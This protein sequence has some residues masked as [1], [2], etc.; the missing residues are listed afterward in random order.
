MISSPGNVIIV[1][2]TFPWSRMFRIVVY[3]K[4]KKIQYND[5]ILSIQP[6]SYFKYLLRLLSR[7][8]NVI[9]STLF[10]R[11]KLNNTSC[12][13]SCKPTC[14]LHTKRRKIESYFS[15]IMGL[16]RC[17]YSRKFGFKSMFICGSKSKCISKSSTNRITKVKISRT[18]NDW[19][20]FFD[21]G[22]RLILGA[23]SF[24][25]Q[26]PCDRPPS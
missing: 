19:I 7:G 16:L 5:I 13:S 24:S 22:G 4:I 26:P 9:Y 17:D 3:I 12:R 11:L 25:G 2:S 10:K 8:N 15:I 21:V 23:W 20:M 1:S 14:E 6:T 18:S